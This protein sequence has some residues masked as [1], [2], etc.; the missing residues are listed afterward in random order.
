MS[1]AA[2]VILAPPLPPTLPPNASASTLLCDGLKVI[3]L[4]NFFSAD[5]CRSLIDSLSPALPATDLRATSRRQRLQTDILE[6]P[7]IETI[8]SRL[9]AARALS[10]DA[11]EMLGTLTIDDDGEGLDGQWTASHMRQ[12]L[13]F[14]GYNSTDFYGAHYDLRVSEDGASLPNG[15]E[16][17][18]GLRALLD[19]VSHVT[20]VLYLNENGKDFVGGCTN[21]LN[22]QK[23]IESIAPTTGSALL[24]LQEQVYHEGGAVHSGQK[25]I[26][27]GDVLYRRCRTAEGGEGV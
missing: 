14:A 16:K 11:N 4:D 15:M 5:E 10:P 7:L 26:L 19:V 3:R 6:A 1:E 23:I 18:T 22:G 20:I 25:F 12:R 8:W 21:I 2:S 24:F 27:R 9:C 17:D 13:L